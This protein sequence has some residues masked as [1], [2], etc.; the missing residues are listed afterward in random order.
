MNF[1]FVVFF[2][3]FCTN[4]I[5]IAASI[6]T[7]DDELTQLLN[8]IHTMQATFKQFI[9]NDKGARIGQETTGYMAL[10]RPG[11][12][13]WEVLQP[14]KQLI[15]VNGSKF[16]LYDA[17]LEQVTKRKMNYKKPG[18]SA[19]LLSGSTE[20]LKQMF[21]IIKLKKSGGGIW[22]ELKP[23]KKN[24]SGQTSDYQWIKMHF[25]AGRLSAMHVFDSLG[26][27]SEIHFSNV[28]L[29]SKISQNKF[30]FVA[31]PKV[32]VLDEG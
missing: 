21:K 14:N 8:N 23:E 3:F 18:N 20:T 2:I 29:N 26:Q 24:N 4:T 32:D 12:F 9:V 25:I 10:E 13:R 31:P 22:F 30:V 5:S 6:Q 28:V 7:A 15:I 19:T 27:Q 1:R 17:D 11:K 16:V